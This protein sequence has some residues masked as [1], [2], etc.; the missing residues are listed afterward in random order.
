[1][2]NIIAFLSSVL[3]SHFMHFEF[4]ILFL[5]VSYKFYNSPLFK[6]SF[7]NKG[8]EPSSLW[9]LIKLVQVHTDMYSQLLIFLSLKCQFHT[10]DLK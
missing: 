9:E 5:S 3:I 2:H 6:V 1:M 8:K 4:D 7:V 10:M